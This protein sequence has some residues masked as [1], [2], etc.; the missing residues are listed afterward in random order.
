MRSRRKVRK[1]SRS[2]HQADEQPNR[3]EIGKAQGPHRPFRSVPEAVA[4]TKVQLELARSARAARHIEGDLL[5][6]VMRGRQQR[7]I[8]HVIAQALGNDRLNFSDP[9]VAAAA[10]FSSAHDC[11]ILAPS[12]NASISCSLNISVEGESLFST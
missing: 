5:H 9:S 12:T 2:S 4:V 3:T 7:R 10:S 6:V 8:G 11:T 1:S